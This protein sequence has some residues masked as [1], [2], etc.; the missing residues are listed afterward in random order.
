MKIEIL[1]T[2]L[3]G[4]DRY[5]KGEV[6]G[7]TDENGRYFCGNGWA[8]DQAGKVETAPR[9]QNGEVR[10]DIRGS[11]HDQTADKV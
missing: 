8:K 9:Q 7:V 3:D 4:K 2:F 11:S 10:L 5:E 1:E 6:R